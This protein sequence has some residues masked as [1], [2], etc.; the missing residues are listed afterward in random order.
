GQTLVPESVGF[1]LNAQTRVAV[2]SMKVGVR[3]CRLKRSLSRS[4]RVGK[5][6]PQDPSQLRLAPLPAEIRSRGRIRKIGSSNLIV[7]AEARPECAVIKTACL[8]TD[9]R[10]GIDGAK[11]ASLQIERNLRPRCFRFAARAEQLHYAGHRIRSKERRLRPAHN[12]NVI[13]IRRGKTAEIEG[14]AGIVQRYPVQ[15][16]FVVI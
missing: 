11:V 8:P 14:S 5:I 4:S 6:V 9:A 12:L 7:S 15:Q 2:T 10:A 13:D 1:I 3:D 16:N